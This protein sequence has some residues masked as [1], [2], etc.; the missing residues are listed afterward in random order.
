L[1]IGIGQESP[2]ASTRVMISTAISLSSFPMTG[3]AGRAAALR[4]VAA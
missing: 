1:T 4:L 3:T 2:R